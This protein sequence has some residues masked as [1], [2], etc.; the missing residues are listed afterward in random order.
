MPQ[1][2]LPPSGGRS[3]TAAQGQSDVRDDHVFSAALL[4][5]GGQGDVV[6]FTI[7]KGQNIP[8]LR[9]AAITDT[10]FGH[11]LKYSPLTTNM[12][13]AGET[14]SGIGDVG[15]RSIAIDVEASPY[16]AAGAQSTYGAGPLEMADIQNKVSFTLKVGQKEMTK[17]ALRWYGSGGGAGGTLA[18]ATTAT[19]TTLFP[20]LLRNGD[21]GPRKFRVPIMIERND[22]VEGVLNAAGA[23]VFSVTTGIG[24]PTLVWVNLYSNVRGDV[25]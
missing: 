11:Q 22:T 6:T 12:T 1:I 3:T 25:R 18:V 16:T 7:P 17:G 9:G 4:S 19:T 23:L 8:T 20:A 24:Q 5:S 14:G 13:K 15:V 2:L 10:T 21:A